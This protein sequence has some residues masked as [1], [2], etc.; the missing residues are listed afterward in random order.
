MINGEIKYGG[1]THKS[2]SKLTEED[3]KMLAIEAKN[4]N[5]LSFQ[6]LWLKSLP[7]L[8]EEYK[9]ATKEKD[10]LSYKFFFEMHLIC[11]TKTIY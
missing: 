4:N 9:I 5:W 1:K 10:L 2:I 3:V 6:I 7:V 8:N 11:I